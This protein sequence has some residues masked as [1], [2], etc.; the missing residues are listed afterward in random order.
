MAKPV[1]LDES[2]SSITSIF[3]RKDVNYAGE[4]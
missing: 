2:S 4:T 3:K 1:D